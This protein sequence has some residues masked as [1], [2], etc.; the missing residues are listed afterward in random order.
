M[1]LDPKTETEFSLR[2]DICVWLGAVGMLA[3][4]GPWDWW[5]FAG[6]TVSAFIAHNL[7]PHLPKWMVR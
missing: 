7:R 3:I 2:D 5:W 4:H 1:S 6:I